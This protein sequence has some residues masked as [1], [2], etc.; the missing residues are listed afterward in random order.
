MALPIEPNEPHG[1]R[2]R[3]IE[4]EIMPPL[5]Q[6]KPVNAVALF[7]EF[8]A[9]DDMAQQ[10]F[11][12]YRLDT[13]GIASKV[14][15]DVHG[16]PSIELSDRVNGRC[17]GLCVFNDPGILDAVTPGEHVLIRGNYLAASNLYGI[18]IK[19]SE[20]IRRIQ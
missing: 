9:D 11:A 8:E 3:Q 6:E 5:Q 18:I 15:R 14:Q 4:F 2:M 1:E 10:K 7:R 16:K 19:N 12:Y 20:L 13:E 17:Y